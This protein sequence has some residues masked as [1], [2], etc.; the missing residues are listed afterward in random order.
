MVAN[1]KHIEDS[2]R[3]A[4]SRM[5]SHGNRLEEIAKTIGMHPTALS[6]EIRR[7]RS[8]T[9][10]GEGD[11]LLMPNVLPSLANHKIQLALTIRSSH[12]PRGMRLPHR[13]SQTLASIYRL[14]RCSVEIRHAGRLLI[15]EKQ[16]LQ[17]PR[18]FP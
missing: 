13:E 3:G 7:N 9:K 4:I 2:Q 17:E 1:R 15:S 14:F 5:L 8:K 12:S 18:P 10:Q 16:I 6:R 11:A